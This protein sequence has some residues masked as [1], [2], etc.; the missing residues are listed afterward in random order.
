[1]AAQHPNP[2]SQEKWPQN[3][4]TVSQEIV[5]T[6]SDSDICEVREARAVNV[7]PSASRS[8]CVST[9]V[10]WDGDDDPENPKNW[11]LKYKSMGIVFLS[12]N[13]LRYTLRQRHM[14]GPRGA[15]CQCLS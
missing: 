9:E 15:S 14:R 7:F 3:T 6:R 5:V 10:D 1:M 11:N 4:E 2:E 13:T 8:V 12:W